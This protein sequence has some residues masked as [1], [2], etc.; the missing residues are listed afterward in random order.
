MQFNVPQ[1]I[2]VEDKI[3]GPLTLKQFLY[4]AVGGGILFAL[5]FVVKVWVFII[6]VIPIMGLCLILAFLKV[7]GRSLVSFLGSFIVYLTKPKLYIWRKK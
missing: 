4:L 1:F 3:I 6:L 5:W 7:N 2:E